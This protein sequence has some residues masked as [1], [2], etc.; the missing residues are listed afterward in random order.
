MEFKPDK[1]AKKAYEG[2]KKAALNGDAIESS[3]YLLTGK[4]LHLAAWFDKGYNEARAK[5][6]NVV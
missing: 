6:G 1:S 5:S 2:G 4:G 3:P